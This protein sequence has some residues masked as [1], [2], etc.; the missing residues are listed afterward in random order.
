[1]KKKNLLYEGKAKKVYEGEIPGQVIVEYKDSLT[2]FNAQKKGSFAEKG[3]INCEITTLIFK[4]LEDAGV[5]THWIKNLSSNEM[6]VSQVKIIPLEVVVRNRVAGSL[7]QKLKIEEGK[8]L[9]HPVVEF[10][11]KDDALGDPFL[12]KEQ[13]LALEMENSS[14]LE[15]LQTKALEINKILKNLFA[16]I[17]LD[18]VD[19]KIEFGRN[20]ENEIL[21]ADE[22]TPD[23]CRLW[24]MKTQEKMDKDRFRRDLGK[25]SEAYHEVLSRLQGA[26]KES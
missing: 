22:I 5:A 24:D 18:L 7:A 13:I 26:L 16:K 25:V 15:H 11:Y 12:S 17:N 1:M 2:A 20:R 14:T 19:F 3:R 8:T 9:K 4:V 23:C 21:L 6:L 10:Y